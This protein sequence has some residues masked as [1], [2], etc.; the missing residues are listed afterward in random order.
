M[1]EAPVDVCAS[2]Y[3]G[4]KGELPVEVRKVFV[5]L[6]QGP[7][8]E[9][10]RHPNLWTT[11]VNNEEVLRR[12]LADVFLDL[13][14]DHD[15]K[16]AFTRQADT[17]E[18]EVPHLL[19]TK[20]LNLVESLLLMYLRERLTKAESE[21]VRAIVTSEEI[22]HHMAVYERTDSKD[23]AGFGKR[24]EAAVNKLRT[25]SV[26]HKVRDNHEI[27]LA[28]KLMLTPEDVQSLTEC[29]KRLAQGDIFDP[30][31]ETDEE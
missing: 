7:S 21:G 1:T 20:Q 23:H 2:L 5:H 16:F 30:I 11:L 12:R 31:P 14:L 22:L 28:L 19:R 26:L 29:Y 24:V 13:I 17:G 3:F 15:S 4:D 6:L 27:S 18:I 9:E 8:I 10:R 25:Y